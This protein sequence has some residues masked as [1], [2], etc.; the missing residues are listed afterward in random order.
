MDNKPATISKRTIFIVISLIDAVIAGLL[1]LIYFRLF[2]IDIESWGI[3]RWIVGAV[4]AVW[5]M[6]AVG[7]LAYQLSKHDD[8]E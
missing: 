5:F 6:A 7:I 8:S 2:P 1:L 4:G 3:P